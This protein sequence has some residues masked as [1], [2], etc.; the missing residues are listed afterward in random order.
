MQFLD[1]TP[2]Q[3]KGEGN[4]RDCLAFPVDLYLWYIS[5]SRRSPKCQRLKLQNCSATAAAR[6]CAF[7][8]NSGLRETKCAF[9]RLA[10][11]FCWSPL[12]PTHING[13]RNSIA[14]NLNHS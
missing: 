6:L 1:T 3:V 5:G 4:G 13:L 10:M 9:D 2:S 8:V 14:S 7:H 11:R 12:F